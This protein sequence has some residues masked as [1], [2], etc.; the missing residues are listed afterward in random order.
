MLTKKT[1]SI[2]HSFDNLRLHGL[3]VIIINGV[4]KICVRGEKRK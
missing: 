1:P 2:H 3:C 4:D